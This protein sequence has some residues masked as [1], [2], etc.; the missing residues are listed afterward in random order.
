M[1]PIAMIDKFH[2]APDAGY[3]SV[4]MFDRDSATQILSS[5]SSANLARFPVYT[6]TLILDLDGGDILLAQ[7][8]DKLE[9]LAYTIYSSGGKG[10][11][12]VLPLECLL[13][14]QNVPYSQRRWV[15][16]MG[17]RADLS[18]YQ[19]GHIVSLPGR[20]HPKTGNYKTL[21]YRVEGERLNIPLLDPASHS[22]IAFDTLNAGPANELEKGLWKLIQILRQEP[23]VGNRHVAIWSTAKHLADAGLDYNTIIDLLTEVNVT[24][25][26]PKEISEVAAAVGQAFPPK[27]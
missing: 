13:E 2:R 20:K 23:P 27:K 19:A 4:Y 10:F 18:L 17:I 8:L 1:L 16:G 5:R 9:G 11:H 15:E 25:Q 14:G 21:L 22:S 6:D 3:A 12:V 7:T 24:W 26:N